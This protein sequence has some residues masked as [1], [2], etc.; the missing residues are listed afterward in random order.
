MIAQ[1]HPKFLAA[2]AGKLVVKAPKLP[3]FLISS[4]YTPSQPISIP[5][6]SS[7]GKVLSLFTALYIKDSGK[8]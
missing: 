1:V 7:S 2:V 3:P 5:I 8:R 4:L 6:V